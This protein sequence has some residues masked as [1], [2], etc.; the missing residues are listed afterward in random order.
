[1]LLSKR[2]QRIVRKYKRVLKKLRLAHR[3]NDPEIAALPKFFR[4]CFC[5]QVLS[6]LTACRRNLAWR[7]NRVDATA[8]GFVILYLHGRIDAKLGP[9]A[10]SNQ[11]RQTKSMSQD[12]SIR[13]WKKNGFT[14][15]P[16]VD[17]VAFLKKRMD[18]R[19]KNGAPMLRECVI[20]LGDARSVLER[21]PGELEGQFQLLFTSPPYSAVT[22]H[23]FDQ[24]LRLWMLGDSAIPSRAGVRWKSRFENRAE[25]QKLI[26]DVFERSARLMADD[27]VIYVRTDAREFTR[28]VT[29]DALRKVFRRKKVMIR[30]RPLNGVTQTAL[31]GDVGKKPGEIDIILR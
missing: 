20:K 27:A 10:L 26:E 14:K 28:E 15:P 19:Y 16:N 2:S 25:Y 6:F 23:Y 8:M 31:F 17:P 13:W 4:Y 11:M 12:Y 3:S 30:R 1:M 9:Q 21:L 22:S 7:S 24:W 29:V 18:W 5:P